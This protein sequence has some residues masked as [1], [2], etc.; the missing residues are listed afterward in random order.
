MVHGSGPLDRNENVKGQ[1]LNAFNTM[2][3]HLAELGIASLRYDK[4]GCGESSG[5]FVAAGHRDLVADAVR[6]VDE[7]LLN[8]CCDA[9]RLFVLGHS[10][11]TVI[12]A[13][14]FQ[15]RPRIAGLVLLCPFLE[16]LD[17]VL[18]KQAEQLERELAGRPGFI[19]KPANALFRL[20]GASVA[21]QK[22]LIRRLKLSTGD[23]L[24]VR[25]HKLPARWFREVFELDL[26]AIYAGITCP[27]LIL[28]G[29][30]D[31]Q[32]NPQDV[33]RIG[34]LVAGEVMFE[35]VPD[36]THL[37]R[38]EHGEPRLSA[39]AKLLKRPVEPVLIEAICLWLEQQMTRAPLPGGQSSLASE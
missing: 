37:L 10:E 31:L 34:E 20:L 11:G 35:I 8:D 1:Q 12:A 23:T 29:A 6:W 16:P 25:L 22:R 39:S 38:L 13:Q 28:G 36:L 7:L 26:P 4:R 18:I 19:G 27:T 9:E 24:R 21:K 3:A 32:C 2:A 33:A 17:V 5:E 14:V 30:K 15:A